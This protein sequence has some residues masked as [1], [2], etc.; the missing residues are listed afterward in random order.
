MKV[1]D[2][3]DSDEPFADFVLN[4]EHDKFHFEAKE[5]LPDGNLRV[6]LRCV[7]CSVGRLYIVDPDFVVYDLRTKK[8]SPIKHVELYGGI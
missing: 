1:E 8:F 7:Q 5:K 2:F 3:I 6:L 4:H